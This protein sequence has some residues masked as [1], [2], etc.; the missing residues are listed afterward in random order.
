[1]QKE[2]PKNG[3]YKVLIFP[4]EYIN[5]FIKKEGN[6]PYSDSEIEYYERI[7]GFFNKIDPEI[8]LVDDF[9]LFSP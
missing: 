4:Q 7:I 9:D 5:L 1:M 6:S 3:E 2:L 8:L